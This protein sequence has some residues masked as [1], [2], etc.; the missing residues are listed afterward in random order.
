MI[1]LF[2]FTLWSFIS[3]KNLAFSFYLCNLF[4]FGNY[5]ET[6]TPTL[7]FLYEILLV[8]WWL[9]LIDL[10]PLY[11]Y[12]LPLLP[13]DTL[14]PYPILLTDFFDDITIKEHWVCW[15][16]RTFF[17]S[18]VLSSSLF[19]LLLLYSQFLVDL[20]FHGFSFPLWWFSDPSQVI[21]VILLPLQTT[22]FHYRPSPFLANNKPFRQERN[23][24]SRRGIFN[25]TFDFI[26][27]IKIINT[28]VSY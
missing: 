1:S 3:V 27:F 9:D 26:R 17:W 21:S 4:R 10:F 11:Y 7:G 14:L 20:L 2:V 6:L 12:D 15:I 18:T 16:L 28:L 23:V 25:G 22:S 8:Y 5:S 24:P 19:S 13:G